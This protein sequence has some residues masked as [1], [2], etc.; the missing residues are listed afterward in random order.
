MPGANR[1]DSAPEQTAEANDKQVDEV[2]YINGQKIPE[3]PA[4]VYDRVL[5]QREEEQHEAFNTTVEYGIHKELRRQ[6]RPGHISIEDC[7]F[8]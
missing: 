5:R 2:G 1:T 8:R 4:S 6:T 7:E 3:Q